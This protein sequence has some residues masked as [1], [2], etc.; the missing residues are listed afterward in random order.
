MSDFL[1]VEEMTQARV[2]SIAFGAAAGR[3][4]QNNP[5]VPRAR[6]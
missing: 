3:K 4:F 2:L 1:D 6:R 5:P